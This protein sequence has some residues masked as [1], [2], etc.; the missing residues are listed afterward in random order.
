MMIVLKKQEKPTVVLI[1]TG[2]E[3]ALCVEAAE[4][5]EGAQVVSMPCW[6]LFEEQTAEYRAEVMPVGVPVLSVEALS[7][8][9]WSRYSH[10]QIGM[11]TFGKSGPADDVYRHF[12]ITADAIV[13]KAQR[14]QAAF[15]DSPAPPLRFD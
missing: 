4:K 3:V 7:T 8:F 6:E 13:A 11:T 9:G 14:L 2:T 12:G 5:L 15:K 1:G 10:A